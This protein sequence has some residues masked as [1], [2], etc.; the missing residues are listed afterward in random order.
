MCLVLNGPASCY[1]RAEEYGWRSHCETPSLEE[2]VDAR[3]EHV[4]A[5]SSFQSVPQCSEN[6]HAASAHGVDS[7]AVTQKSSN[8]SSWSTISRLQSSHASTGAFPQ[9]LK[10]RCGTIVLSEVWPEYWGLTVGQCREFLDECR[11]CPE[12][13]SDTSVATMVEEYVKP[14]TRGRGIGYALM[15]NRFAPLQV[16]IMVSHCWSE[17]AE[18]F[19]ETLERTVRTDDV[20]F[21]CAFSLY[22]CEDGSGPSIKEQLGGSAVDS[23]FQRVLE[24]IRSVGEAAS[25]RWTHSRRGKVLRALPGIGI[26]VSVLLFLYPI[27]FYQCVPGL[28]RCW[29]H[30]AETAGFKDPM[31]E[32]DKP[33]SMDNRYIEAP[34]KASPP[35]FWA[36]SALVVFVSSML[37]LIV[38]SQCKLYRG[39]M[40]AVP[41]REVD[42]YGR[43]WCVYEI[44][45][46]NTVGVPVTLAHT[47]ASAGSCSSK[48]ARCSDP[49][50]T[51]R[52]RG[53]IE[54]AS[55]EQ[56]STAAEGY[57][58]VDGC[59]KRMM[60]GLRFE[61]YS[62]VTCWGI[63][64]LADTSAQAALARTAWLDASDR[65]TN[66]LVL[67]VWS[68]GMVSLCIAASVVY[69][70]ARHRQGA[71]SMTR[72]CCAITG[73]IVFAIGIPS[74]MVITLSLLV[75]SGTDIRTTLDDVAG[76]SDQDDIITAFVQDVCLMIYAC[77]QPFLTLMLIATTVAAIAIAA[78]LTTH[79]CVRRL[80]QRPTTYVGI[81]V[82]FA[83]TASITYARYNV[84]VKHV[85][86]YYPIVMRTLLLGP[87]VLGP[88]VWLPAVL[89][90]GTLRWG[91]RLGRHQPGDSMCC[92]PLEPLLC[93]VACPGVNE[94][95][96]KLSSSEGTSSSDSCSD[97]GSS[98][99]TDPALSFTVC[100]SV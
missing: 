34:A 91:I 13:S 20:L 6:A 94:K 43:L 85:R 17:N 11:R 62:A 2:R 49:E 63:L 58:A 69:W 90:W 99:C 67:F 55:M 15:R 27:L 72:A 37:L 79:D 35:V 64:Y 10:S 89:W 23:P 51:N 9:L 65:T 93:C 71:P 18:E 16:N 40:I 66:L 14:T 7:D 86:E 44:F 73:L 87:R 46:A 33:L 75:W 24:H 42:L 38:R 4:L 61:F 59:I 97:S 70:M 45:V 21:I 82:A 80:Q 54:T 83:L 8:G 96:S 39:K 12:W 92:S 36:W 26:F 48:D 56:G 31:Q 50:D 52:I 76:N 53:E 3:E 100:A 22:Q 88:F 68:A 95:R 30:A 60:R 41:N 19:I 5:C 29:M 77:C 98:T 81:G 1:P 25:W 57:R 74:A 78:K 32:E 47:L 28:D 84:D